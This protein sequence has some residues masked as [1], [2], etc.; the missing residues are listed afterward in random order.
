MSGDDLT[1][2]HLHIGKESLVS[3]DEATMVKK[4]R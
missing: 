3:P 1:V 4:F 2:F